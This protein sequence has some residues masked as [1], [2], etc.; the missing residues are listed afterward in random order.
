MS[1]KA[2]CFNGV[3][4]DRSVSKGGNGPIFDVE[5]GTLVFGGYTCR[6]EVNHTV[7]GHIRIDLIDVKDGQFV[8]TASKADPCYP[9][10]LETVL[11]KDYSENEGMLETLVN[12][13]VVRDTGEMSG[14]LH[15]C[16]LIA[17]LPEN[18]GKPS[19][20]L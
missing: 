12:A 19:S 3:W 7:T 15:I 4:L 9:P 2:D 8:I 5:T 1:G 10:L 14:L 20:I 13:N 6:L 18:K 17:A 11:I 16:R